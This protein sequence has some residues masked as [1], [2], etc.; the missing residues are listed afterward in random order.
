MRISSQQVVE[1]LKYQGL[2]SEYLPQNFN[3]LSDNCNIFDIPIK[4][5]SDL[6][7]PLTFTMSR[8]TNDEQR[9]N[10]HLPEL[11][12]YLKLVKYIEDQHITEE[13]IGFSSESENSFSKVLHKDGSI[14]KHEVNYNSLPKHTEGEESTK[15]TFIQN[16]VEKINRA[17]GAKG[18]LFVDIANFYGSIYTHLFPA[19]PLGF[20]EA[21]EQYKIYMANKQDENIKE[22]YVKY[23]NLDKKIRMLN[24][25][26]TN[27]LLT[28]PNISFI[29][30]ES[31]LTRIDIELKEEGIEFVRYMDDYEVF[32]YDE[33]KIDKT[34]SKVIKVLSKYY[35]SLNNE[36]TE[37]RSYPYFKFKNL[38]RIYESFTNDELEEADIIELFN[39][40]FE[41]EEDGSKGAV[42][43]LIKTIDDN[44]RTENFQLFESFLINV[45][46]NDNR[47][48]LKTC[49][50][51]IK[52]KDSLEIDGNFVELIE[53]LI[54]QYAN[55]HKDLEVIWLLYLLKSL[56]ETAI[57]H[58]TVKRVV[59]SENELAIIILLE[60]YEDSITDEIKKDIIDSANSWILLY[61]LY[62]KDWIEDKEFEECAGIKHNLPFYKKLK[63]NEFTFY[64][65]ISESQ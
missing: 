29:L 1:E 53:S 38:E 44:F 33:S 8:F 35:L 55:S 43:Y 26:R 42:R 63:N 16:I 56:S 27:G 65:K 60:E 23:I 47:S 30:A 59:V 45:L 7:E 40:F 58:D 50:L 51:L 37:Y 61:Q 17:K 14:L 21:M 54:V 39:K 62:L 12:N 36:K 28:G 57:E 2:F 3:L 31:L 18:I 34:K 4:E 19:I 22:E 9:R 52:E 5:K 49:E 11:T 10:I 15:S 48:L 32:I 20:E 25:G 46:V 64:K 13:L 6:I 41:L 24:G